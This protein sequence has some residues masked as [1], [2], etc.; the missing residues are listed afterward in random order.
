[1]TP[2]TGT[3]V[4]YASSAASS[5]ISPRFFSRLGIAAGVV[6][7]IIL[8]LPSSAFAVDYRSLKEAAI[9][10][11]SPSQKGSKLYVIR[12]YTPVELIIGLEGWLKVRDASGGIAWVEKSALSTQRTVQVTADQAQVRESASDGAR[13]VFEAEKGVALE[14]VSVGPVGWAKVKHLDGQTGFIRISQVWGV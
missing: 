3:H 6:L 14:L 11:D 7:G 12:R 4:P 10:Y 1:M 9:L 5:G 8:A 13:I 2:R